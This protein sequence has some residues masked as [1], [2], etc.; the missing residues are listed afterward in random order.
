MKW[1]MEWSVIT[2]LL[3]LSLCTWDVAAEQYCIIGA[4]PGGLWA[5]LL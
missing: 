3:S 2:T 5:K 1:I 4:G